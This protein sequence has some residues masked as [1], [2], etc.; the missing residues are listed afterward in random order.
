MIFRRISEHIGKQSWSAVGLDL[1]VVVVGI[2]LGLQ[3]LLS[4]LVFSRFIQ[5]AT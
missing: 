2:Y 3:E 4:N 1:I 5:A